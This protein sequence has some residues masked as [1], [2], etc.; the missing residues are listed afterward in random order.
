VRHTGPGSL[1]TDAL[2]RVERAH[3]E[4]NLSVDGDAG[5][6]V[7]TDTNLDTALTEPLEYAIRQQDGEPS[8]SLTISDCQPD[9]T[10]IDVRYPGD[11]VSA[12]D[13][14]VLDQGLETPLEHCRGLGLWLAKWII[15]NAHGH[16]EFPRDGDPQIRIELYRCLG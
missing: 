16:L 14:R 9:R 10:R 11:P 4:A 12:N 5:V 3:P 13:R 7:V 15:E 1:V 6:P 2:E 8:V